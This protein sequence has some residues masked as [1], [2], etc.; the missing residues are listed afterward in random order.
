M[1]IKKESG[2]RRDIKSGNLKNTAY[3]IIDGSISPSEACSK[4]DTNLDPT[5]NRNNII[6]IDVVDLKTSKLKLF[7][8][9]LFLNMP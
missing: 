9:I 8:R 4:Y 5:T 2:R 1:P 7:E 3:K 6:N